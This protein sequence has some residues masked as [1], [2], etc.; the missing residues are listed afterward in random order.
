DIFNGNLAVAIAEGKGLIEAAT[1]ANAA[2]ALSVTRLGAQRS[3]P[4]RKEI[5]RFVA[6]GKVPSGP[7]EDLRDN[8]LHED[9]GLPEQKGRGGRK[10]ASNGHEASRIEPRRS[11]LASGF[12]A[13]TASSSKVQT[14]L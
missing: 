1:F 10:E 6:T 3:A 13:K 11:V 4:T 2:A 9:D 8:G 7:E 12:G 14:L 5:E